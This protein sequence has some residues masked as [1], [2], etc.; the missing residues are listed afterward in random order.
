MSDGHFILL[1]AALM[2]SAQGDSS[3]T[4]AL[5]EESWADYQVAKFTTGRAR[6]Y[7]CQANCPV[8]A[9][10]ADDHAI[11]PYFNPSTVSSSC[12]AFSFAWTPPSSCNQGYSG[13]GCPPVFAPGMG[14]DCVSCAKSAR[15]CS[16]CS[17]AVLCSSTNG[18]SVTH[19]GVTNS[20]GGCDN[21]NSELTSC[22]GSGTACGYLCTASC[23]TPGNCD[24]V[25]QEEVVTR[26]ERTIVDDPNAPCNLG[27]CENSCMADFLERVQ[28]GGVSGW[29]N[30][31]PLQTPCFPSDAE[32]RFANGTHGR[33]ESL[34]VGDRILAAQTDG[35]LGVDTVRQ[36]E[37][38]RRH[39]LVGGEPRE[40]GAT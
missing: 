15:Q 22:D 29:T 11:C 19:D 1:V 40:V 21:S 16:T 38:N 3:C 35:T 28:Q 17:A 9:T 18:F 4:I 37:L 26:C 2:A 27:A 5:K 24:L 36:L 25:G 14:D 6:K 30:V 23:N 34:E 32:V 33:I 39:M 31:Y 20:L 13:A 12:N 8:S 7:W 10:L